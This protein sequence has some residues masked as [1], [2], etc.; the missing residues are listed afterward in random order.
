MRCFGYLIIWEKVY[1]TP[2]LQTGFLHF[3][4]L[5]ISVFMVVKINLKPIKNSKIYDIY[6]VKKGDEEV[7]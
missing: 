7:I 6:S 1:Q 3:I 2:K 4:H 5:I